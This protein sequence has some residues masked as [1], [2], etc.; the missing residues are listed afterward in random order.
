[1]N[2]SRVMRPAGA[3]LCLAVCVIGFA[4]FTT[5]AAGAQ[6]GQ[7]GRLIVPRL[8]APITLDGLSDEP[9]WLRIE[10]LP[11]VTQSP[12][13][14]NPPSE[15]TEIRLA[16]DDE[17]I[18]VAGR[19]YDEPGDIRSPSLKRDELASNNDYLGII[20]DTFNDNENALGFFTTPRGIRLDFSVEND[21]QPPN[22][23]DIPLNRSWDTFWDAATVI[24]DE[25]WFAEI[26][27]PLASLRFADTGD[28]VV[29]GVLI[30]RYI[31]SIPEVDI[32][33]AVDLTRGEW[34][35]FTPS[36]GH[37]AVFRNIH[38]HRPV[39]LTPYVLAGEGIGHELNDPETAWLRD[40][41]H[42]R[43]A[44]L[45]LKYSLTSNLTLD[46]T[47]NTDFAQVEADDQQVNLTRF[48]LFFPE[49]RRFFQE[50]ASN[51]AVNLGGNQS[52][53]YSRR[54]GLHEGEQIPILGGVRLVGRA[55]QWDVGALTMQ[56]AESSELPSENFGVVRLRRQVFN[57][58]SY[59]GGICTSRIGTDG[60][61]NL[62]WGLDGII[63]VF[64]DDYLNLNLAR[65]ATDSTRY[66]LLAAAPVRFHLMWDRRR[67]DG[68]F[69]SGAIA[70]SGAAFDPASGFMMLED[71][72]VARASV[73]WGWI[74]SD[75][76]SAFLQSS[77]SAL[78]MVMHNDSDGS[79]RTGE[80]TLTFSGLTRNACGL[81]LTATARTENLDEEFELSDEVTVPIGRYSF[82]HLE[83][84]YTTRAGGMASCTVSLTTGGYFDGRRTSLAVMPS[85]S[86]SEYV[87]LQGHYELNRIAF[88]DR[89]KD[90]LIQIGRL[91]LQL[92]FSTR[93][94][95]LSF[96]QYN[97]AADVLVAN[98]RLR[99]N[100]REGTDLYLVYN[101]GL[102]TDRLAE[103][104]PRPLTGNRTLMI[105]YA[106][107]FIF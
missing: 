43:E 107:T 74:A 66:D 103:V 78:T 79:L 42:T 55:G 60:R 85:W 18:Y 105:K 84:F 39:Y 13:F 88:P 106:R 99:Y 10:P 12:Y 7:D 96:V 38:S 73:G 54:I 19:M 89:D 16:C 59:L 36:R 65:T 24:T 34:S 56:T 69:Y 27:I 9:A 53:F 17:Y 14:G 81:Y 102:N 87:N 63:R 67:Q 61:R 44:G 72:R 40:R 80:H 58:N 77:V 25:G 45:D 48:S 23:G 11:L 50:R 15:Q 70:R 46:V 35:A 57:E 33:P 83:A 21:A 95:L 2:R 26:R 86:L 1:M 75:E 76:R 29:M 49:K 104:P 101:E 4:P 100:P 92:T 8:S 30:W 91:R 3:H 94:S 31:A 28:E 32:F 90:L 37:D 5:R 64:G 52:L 71:Y 82:N 20:L 97:S 68:F 47:L 51:F 62:T 6:A 98:L 41:T 22:P 93:L